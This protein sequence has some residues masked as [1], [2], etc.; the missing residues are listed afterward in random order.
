MTPHVMHVI[1]AEG[2]IRGKHLTWG[3][4]GTGV[5]MHDHH[6]CALPTSRYRDPG[7]RELC[8]LSRLRPK[9]CLSS[10]DSPTHAV[11][12]IRR[13]HVAWGRAPDSGSGLRWQLG[14]A[15][16]HFC[17]VQEVP[18]PSFLVSDMRADLDSLCSPT[19]LYHFIFRTSLE[20]SPG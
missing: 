5:K 11:F 13:H 20:G 17:G 8:T 3:G 1:N 2:T 7:F 14:W 16:R 10:G 6:P 19:W 12:L 18:E 4:I 15:A 9:V